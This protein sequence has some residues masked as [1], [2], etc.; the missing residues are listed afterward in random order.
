MES[1][2]DFERRASLAAII[3][4]EI[5]RDF[6]EMGLFDAARCA[7]NPCAMDTS[8]IFWCAEFAELTGNF[9]AITG[10]LNRNNRE[11]WCPKFPVIF[12]PFRLRFGTPMSF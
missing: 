4:R 6:F 1:T 7:R 3:N 12:D 2:H 10:N 9:F 5:Y 8:R 11:F